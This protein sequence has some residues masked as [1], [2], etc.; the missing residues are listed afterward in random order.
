MKVLVFG[1]GVIGT[2]HA[3]AFERAGHTVTLFARPGHEDR[4]AN[5]VALRI[6]D[7]RG[8]RAEETKVLYRP[9]S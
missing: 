9:R 4:W 8:G 5:G 3:W 7:G 2:L 6:L 1:A